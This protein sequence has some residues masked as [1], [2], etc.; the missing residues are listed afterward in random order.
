MNNN[1]ANRKRYEYKEL[2][3]KGLIRSLDVIKPF[4]S[5]VVPN[6]LIENHDVWDLFKAEIKTCEKRIYCVGVDSSKG[7][8]ETLIV[9]KPL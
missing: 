7:A 2:P 3:T 5:V 4:D 1:F 6:T 9:F 8:N